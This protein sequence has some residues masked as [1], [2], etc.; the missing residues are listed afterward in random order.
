M[1][2]KQ[3]VWLLTMLSLMIVLSAYY[4]ISPEGEELAYIE[5][6]QPTSEETVGTES[7]DT[8][9]EVEDIS[10][11]GQD[12]MFTTIRME[13][14]DERSAKKERLTDVV[15]SA[16]ANAEEKAEATE[17]IDKLEELSTKE[18]ILEEQIIGATGYPDVLVRSD[19]SKVH[20]HV[21]AEEL[22]SSE[23]VNIMQM[24]R[25]EFG[26]IPAE[27][28]FQSTGTDASEM[29]GEA[30]GETE[31]ENDSSEENKTEE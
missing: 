21:K 31:Q 26:E 14:Q 5:D 28:N 3:T 2:K 22:S 12:E 19:G 13:I 17:E 11:V 18:S 25:D 7:E 4:L 15:A 23:V 8:G 20:I 29:E 24:S 1:L 27:V 10:N 9:A 16:N 6:G 30:E